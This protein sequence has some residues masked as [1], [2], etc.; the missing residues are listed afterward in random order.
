VNVERVQTSFQRIGK[1]AAEVGWRITVR[2]GSAGPR[3]VKLLESL[4]GQW[5]V[6]NADAPYTA[7]DAGTIEFDL[8]DVPPS[9]GKEGKAINYTVR[10]EY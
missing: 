7:K 8:K 10:F 2:N 3:D 5:T 6:L 1:N 9:A 4:A